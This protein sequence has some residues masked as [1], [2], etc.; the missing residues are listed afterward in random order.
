MESSTPKS[1][2][3]SLFVRVPEALVIALRVDAAQR[4]RRP[5]EVVTEL[6]RERYGDNG[7][8]RAA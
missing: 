5:S 3:R 1:N 6:L 4:D 2:R 8:G 7:E